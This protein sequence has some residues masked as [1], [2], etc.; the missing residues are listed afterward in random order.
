[1]KVNKMGNQLYVLQDFKVLGGTQNRWFGYSIEPREFKI[2]LVK[3]SFYGIDFAILRPDVSPSCLE[4][5]GYLVHKHEMEKSFVWNF[6]KEKENEK[7]EN[8]FT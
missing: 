4:L 6:L 7:N 1:M 3:P 8:L 2:V 5:D